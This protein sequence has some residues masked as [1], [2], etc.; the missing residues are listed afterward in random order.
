MGRLGREIRSV[1]NPALG[2]T[3]IASATSGYAVGSGTNAG[4]PLPLAFLILPIVLH[5]ATY[6]LLSG[7]MKKSGLRLFAE[8]FSQAKNAQSDL[9][10][11][12][13]NRAIA[14]RPIT[15]E[16]LDTMLC[17]GIV[18]LDEKSATLFASESLG[19]VLVGITASRKL[20]TDSEKL[21]FWFGQV[22]AFELSST[23]KVAF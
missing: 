19:R 8:K 2:A 5:A 3:L 18:A 13:Q 12:I 1:Q 14:M 15:F 17:S 11:A 9:I 23:L 10:L 16:A 20:H 4:M 22:T 21:G 6:E 7:T